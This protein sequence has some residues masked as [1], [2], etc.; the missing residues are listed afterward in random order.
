MSNN[1]SMK[2]M[3]IVKKSKQCLLS[4]FAP[5]VSV[6]NIKKLIIINFV[7]NS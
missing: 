4:V 7:K 2:M 1:N 5:L 3:N 6:F